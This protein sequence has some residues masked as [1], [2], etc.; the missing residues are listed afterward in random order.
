MKDITKEN[1][2]QITTIMHRTKNNADG[3]PVRARSNGKLK[4]WKTRPSEW[5]L[6]MKYG[7]KECFYLGRS[8]HVHI[9]Q[10]PD[11]WAIPE[12]GEEFEKR[13]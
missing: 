1:A 9:D 11:D 12:N 4:L 6:P 3:T 10:D 7:L 2:A 13:S 8:E 5:R